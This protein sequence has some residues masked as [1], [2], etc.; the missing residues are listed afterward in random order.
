MLLLHHPDKNHIQLQNTVD[1]SVIKDAYA[2]LSDDKTRQ[3]Y[4]ADLKSRPSS[5]GSRP[6][7][8]VS[9]DVFVENDDLVSWS[10]HCRCSG[11]Y[12]ITELQMDSDVHLIGCSNCS[13]TVYVGYELADD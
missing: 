12:T 2:I 7:E 10:F 11:R 5:S 3:K 4:D 6:A 1:I 9:L 13:E 8:L